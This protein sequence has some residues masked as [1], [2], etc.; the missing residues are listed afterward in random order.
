MSRF[1]RRA[2]FSPRRPAPFIASPPGSVGQPAKT[3]TERSPDY[4][5]FSGRIGETFYENPQERLPAEVYR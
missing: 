5:V 4:G 1:S 3:M 2:A